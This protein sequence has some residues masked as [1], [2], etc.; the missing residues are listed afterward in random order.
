MYIYIHYILEANGDSRQFGVRFSSQSIHG[1]VMGPRFRDWNSAHSGGWFQ[2]TQGTWWTHTCT[3]T[4]KDIYI[5]TYS[6]VNIYTIFGI[7]SST[8]ISPSPWFHHQSSG[9]PPLSFVACKMQALNSLLESMWNH[10]GVVAD[11]KNGR[12]WIVENGWLV[13]SVKLG[14]VVAGKSDLFIYRWLRNPLSL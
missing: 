11:P 3:R 5:Y 2:Q 6:Y 14:R 7:I 13:H 9:F 1:E 4:C 10:R 8:S 12:F